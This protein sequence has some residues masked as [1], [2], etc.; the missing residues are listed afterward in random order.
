[1]QITRKMWGCPGP[2]MRD[3]NSPDLTD[4]CLCHHGTTFAGDHVRVCSRRRTHTPSTTCCTLRELLTACK[5]YWHKNKLRARSSPTSQLLTTSGHVPCRC[6]HHFNCPRQLPGNPQMH[7]V[8]AD[9]NAA[10]EWRLDNV[11]LV[12]PIRLDMLGA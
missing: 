2:Q 10:S 4:P 5:T 11:H 7:D 3:C 8:G 9:E 12:P 6:C 1:M